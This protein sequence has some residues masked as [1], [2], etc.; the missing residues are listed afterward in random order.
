MKTEL[1]ITLCEVIETVF[2][3]LDIVLPLPIQ[4]VPL[5]YGWNVWLEIAI[6][7]KDNVGIES[8]SWHD[9][10]RKQLSVVVG[11]ERVD[12]GAFACKPWNPTAIPDWKIIPDFSLVTSRK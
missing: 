7:L 2:M 5:D 12:K 6:Y 9:M 4:I 8:I 11:R 1:E 10:Q 3:F